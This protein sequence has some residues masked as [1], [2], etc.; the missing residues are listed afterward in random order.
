MAVDS[1]LFKY[2]GNLLYQATMAEVKV[3]KTDS[4]GPPKRYNYNRFQQKKG[5]QETKFDGRCDDIK[6][7]FSTAPTAS[8]PI[9]TTPPY[10]RSPPMHTELMTTE[11]T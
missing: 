2:Y 9:G 1:T 7:F 11:E 3:K 5:N 6:G 8:M 4:S 10:G